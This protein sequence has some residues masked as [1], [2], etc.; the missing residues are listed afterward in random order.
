MPT[1]RALT[2]AFAAVLLVLP[3]AHAQRRKKKDPNAF[4]PVIIRKKE[5]EQKDETQALPVL[6]EPPAATVGD[7]ERLTFLV[8]PLSGKGLL[9]QQTREALRWL[10]S[11]SRGGS[12]L[13][14][15]AF[16]AG[17]GDVRRV[18][19]IVSETFTERK[20]NL[21]ALTVIQAGALPLEGAQVVLEAMLADRRAINEHGVALFSAQ[22]GTARDPLGALDA[23]LRAT[24]LD[25][26]DVRRITCFVNSFDL[27][28]AAA[29]QARTSYPEAALNFVQP[30]R[31]ALDDY[32]ECEAVARLKR[33]P[34]KRVLPV[35][36]QP[37]QFAL[38]TLVGPGRVAVSSTQM[39]F[40]TEDKD[41]RLVYERLGKALE[42]VGA[43]Y[44]GVVFTR[45]YTVA[46]SIAERANKLRYEFHGQ[47][48][49]PSGVTLVCEGMLS[50]DA[51][52]GIEA[53]AMVTEQRP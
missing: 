9:S 52:V 48:T 50:P 34:S 2:A 26:G 22:R 21:P 40:Q 13:K 5:K 51:H 8:S 53:Y 18:Q 39:A 23:A 35:E 20:L 45:V 24:G 46:R 25:G 14:L 3:P 41:L 42:G 11:N 17:T 43:G 38:A 47:E 37:G 12:V 15:R 49:A 36:P 27:S 19:E 4:P 1:L 44:K 32:A 31:G 7:V 10:F 16:V 28:A 6:R 29:Q 33:P 30:L